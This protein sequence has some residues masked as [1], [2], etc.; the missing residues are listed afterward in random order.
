[1]PYF[2]VDAPLLVTTDYS[3][4]IDSNNPR[5]TVD[6]SAGKGMFAYG[7]LRMGG[8]AFYSMDITD[9]SAPEILF[10]VTKQG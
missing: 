5:V 3:Y 10:K 8:E 1:Q 9:L 6:T 7:G 2:G 4:D